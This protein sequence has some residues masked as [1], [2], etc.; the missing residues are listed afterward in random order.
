MGRINKMKVE[1][2]KIGLKV[3]YD[4]EMVT[5]DEYYPQVGNTS[6]SG[7]VVI[8]NYITNELVNHNELELIKI[9]S[10]LKDWGVDTKTAII[11]NIILNSSSYDEEFKQQL[12]EFLEDELLH[13]YWYS[14]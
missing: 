13:S 4:D 3:N 12:C 8:R 9:D 5:I 6:P 2:I 14:N 7:D 11:N 10:N 1:D